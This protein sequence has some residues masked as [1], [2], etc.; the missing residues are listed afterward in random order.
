MKHSDVRVLLLQ[1]R[2]NEDMRQHELV[3]FC[4]SGRLELSQVTAI[5]GLREELK[6]EHL[7]GKQL[8]VIGGSGEYS[9]FEK[10]PFIPVLDT[11]LARCR[12]EDIPLFGSCWGGQYMAMAL[13]G[14][15]I[16]DE[17]NE[18]VGSFE[19][20]TTPAA[21]NDQ[22]FRGFPAKF[23]AQLG[24]HQRVS[25]LPAGAVTLASSERCP[26]QAFTWPGSAQYGFQFHA[27]LTKEGL[28]ER[29]TYYQESYAP[30]PGVLEALI[31]SVQASP[32]TDNLLATFI[33]RVVLPRY[34][35]AATT[36]C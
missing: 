9:V 27:E 6:P 34:A 33:E 23:V 21:A 26:V 7:D 10:L 35:S 17:A 2:L 31:G 36:S 20:S 12:A 5:D 14:E 22:L 18:E 8:F 1:V 24:H 15:V 32:Q 13:G 11:M 28:I 29:I 25:R 16:T 4:R 19:L 3:H 30:Q